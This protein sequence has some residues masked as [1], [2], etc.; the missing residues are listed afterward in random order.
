[1]GAAGNIIYMNCFYQRCEIYAYGPVMNESINHP[2]N[3]CTGIIRQQTAKELIAH[4]GTFCNAALLAPLSMADLVILKEA[5]NGNGY[6]SAIAASVPG[7][8]VNRH[9]FL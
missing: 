8:Y 7:S 6:E 2:S 4:A 3:L 1:M 9:E 5:F